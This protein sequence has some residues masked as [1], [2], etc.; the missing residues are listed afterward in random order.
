MKIV[1]HAGHA[2]IQE[3][4]GGRDFDRIRSLDQAREVVHEVDDGGPNGGLPCSPFAAEPRVG[5]GIRMMSQ[6]LATSPVKGDVTIVLLPDAM[7]F[8]KLSMLFPSR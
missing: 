6:V 7:S 3:R 2:H 4:E 8:M 1:S 5:L